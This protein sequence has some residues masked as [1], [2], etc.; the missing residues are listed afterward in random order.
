MS[1][2]PPGTSWLRYTASGRS[3]PGTVGT[4]SG[5]DALARASSR[6]TR[7]PSARLAPTPGGRLVLVGAGP[8]RWMVTPR[9]PSRRATAS[10]AP[11]V[12]TTIPVASTSRA[13]AATATRRQPGHAGRAGH[14]GRRRRPAARGRRAAGSSPSSATTASARGGVG[15]CSRWAARSVSAR[16]SSGSVMS[17]TTSSMR[18]LRLDRTRLVGEDHPQ[19][20]EGPGDA[21]LHGAAPAP[22]D[23]R[24]LRL[25][26][27]QEEPG[28]DRLPV[29]LRQAADSGQQRAPALVGQ[30][31]RLG[32]RG[33][34]S[35]RADLGDAQR[36]VVLAATG[37]AAV[38]GLVGDDGEQ[39]GPERRSRAEAVQGVP[40]LHQ[41]LLRGV[42]GVGAAAG[43]QV[44][45][46]VCEILVPA[47]QGLVGTHVSP[48]RPFDELAFVLVQWTALHCVALGHQYTGAAGRVPGPR[49]ATSR[50]YRSVGYRAKRMLLGPPLRTTQLVH[51]RISKR[52]ALAV[53]SSDPISSTAY[54]TEEMLLVVS[55]RQ[56]IRAYPRG[57]G[58]Y[59][60]SR[61]NL[62]PVF[63]SVCGAALLIDYVLTVAVSVS[64]GTAAL[65]SVVE[66]IGDRRVELSVAFIVLLTCGNLR[67]IREAG[68]IFA[69][70]T[71]LYIL[72]LGGVV[73]YGIWRTLLSGLGPVSYQDAATTGLVG[74][75]GG[76]A[77]AVTP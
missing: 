43:D 51:E 66:P 59:M 26:Q 56:V 73:L 42:V 54:A 62:G 4:S 49:P 47:H 46:P 72:S 63:A 38:A 28:G 68:K 71:Y 30:C 44:G 22:E 64:A 7:W 67:G 53:F 3:K 45:R 10:R 39:P 75:E 60:V 50:R 6:P 24:C 1:T 29:P 15:G 5:N 2:R 34:V 58:A 11:G 35:R 76:V 14:A 16:S 41:A 55:Y 31:R 17:L 69:V 33:R 40:G 8:P 20:A 61:D 27:L 23:A 77:V 19:P 32:R 12:A 57:G 25:G 48:S 13:S 70:P 37:A 74:P 9:R 65:A 18:R 36:Q 52:I 21:R